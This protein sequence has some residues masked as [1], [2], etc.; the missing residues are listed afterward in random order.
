VLITNVMLFF[1]KAQNLKLLLQ[2]RNSELYSCITISG[3]EV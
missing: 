2:M 1:E 3:T